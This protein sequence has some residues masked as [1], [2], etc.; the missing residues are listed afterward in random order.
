M[1][2]LVKNRFGSGEESVVELQQETDLWINKMYDATADV[3]FFNKYLRSKSFVEGQANMYE[4]LE[5]LN[6]LLEQCH[7][8]LLDLNQDLRNHKYDLEGMLECDDI[9]CDAFYHEQHYQ[10]KNRFFKFQ[11]RLRNL[12]TQIFNYTGDLL[13]SGE[14]EHQI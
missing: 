13:K 4:N 7:S 9:S 5:K 10:I 14:K 12:Q 3:R 6:T 8:D 1:A 2:T 11:E